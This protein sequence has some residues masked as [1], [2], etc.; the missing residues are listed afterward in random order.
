[1]PPRRRRA[2]RW[3]RLLA[4]FGGVAVL[5]AVAVVAVVVFTRGSHGYPSQW[6][7]RVAPIAASVEEL[8]G[9]TFKH[10]VPVKYLSDVDFEKQ[11]TE[12]PADLKKERKQIDEATGLFRA[13]GLI[14]ANVDLAQ[15]AND[16]Q[17][18]DTIAFY[19]PD[20]KSV[21]VRG[22]GA[23]TVDTRVTLAHE[24][25]HV[26]QDQY[27]DLPKLEK[28]ADASKSGSSDAL[29]GLV[30]GDAVRIQNLYLGE[31]SA[32]D[33]QEYAR[34]SSA[35]ASAAG[36]RTSHI[37]AVVGTLF[38]APYIFG[39][40]LV[41]VLDATGGNS[42]INA[43]L[44]GPTPTTRVY[45]DP[46]AV[47]HTTPLPPTPALKPGEKKLPVTSA[48]DDSF[49]DFTL[50][51]MLS[52]RLD[53]PT[54]LRVADAYAAGSEV[55]YTRG[56]ATCFRAAIVGVDPGSDAF[57]G[58]VLARWTRTMPDAGIDAVRLAG[59]VPLVRSGV[60]CR[61]AERRRDQSGDHA[62]GEP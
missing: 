58:R 32:S 49:D 47:S 21:Y 22:T 55:V 37:P 6:D 46:T 24:L 18:A 9:L 20:T 38:N 23:F 12:S 41:R 7:A 62:R 53:R 59:R 42:A 61:D 11:V 33:R 36:D 26:L 56:G 3:P 60:A 44:T 45:L 13:A 25:T 31:Q 43:A 2:R 10:P 51:L 54:A 17:A 5:A 4:A 8:R 19:D 52:A 50:Y 39:P 16:T 27:F 30:E 40:E 35:G 34:L 1:M 29:R 48:N 14:G 57:L 15:A 28:K